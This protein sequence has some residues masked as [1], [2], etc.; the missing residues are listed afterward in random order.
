M[1]YHFSSVYRRLPDTFGVKPNKKFLRFFFLSQFFL[2]ATIQILCTPFIGNKDYTW[3]AHFL[4]KAPK[5]SRLYIHYVLE[6]HFPEG[7]PFEL[8]NPESQ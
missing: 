4:D 8:L 1:V 6:V 2:Y 3:K 5:F 7:F